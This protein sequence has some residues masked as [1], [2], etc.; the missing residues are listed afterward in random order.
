MLRQDHIIGRKWLEKS[1]LEPPCIKAKELFL[2]K[3]ELSTDATKAQPLSTEFSDP[4]DEFLLLSLGQSVTPFGVFRFF[5]KH[6][7]PL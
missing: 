5:N 6:S 1:K 3:T 2:R 4:K 7:F